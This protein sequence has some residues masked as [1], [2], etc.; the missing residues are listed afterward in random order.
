MISAFRALHR[1]GD[2][3]VLP[4][5]WDHASAA[6]LAEA[7]FPAI[8]TTS[9]GVAAA[10]GLH[11]GAAETAQ[12]TIDLAHRLTHLPVPITMDI[13]NGFSTDPAE[14]AAYLDRLGPVAGVN[15]EDQLADP[16]HF[17]QVLVAVTAHDVF[18]NARIDTYWLGD[19]GVDATLERAKAYVAAGAD[20]IFVPGVKEPQ[21]IARLAEALD[22]PLN[23]LFLPG[24]LTVPQLAE[25]G[26]A[27]ISTGSLLYRVAHGAAID[28]A[29]GVRDGGRS[30]AAPPYAAV[31]ALSRS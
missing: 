18:I 27:R 9:L 3:L 31:D 12:A 23:V 20:G 22:V 1:P 7:G 14:V 19:G 17:A 28:A 15:L 6:A 8:G 29:L 16:H 10:L 2:P 5:A 24:T 26:V 30:F 13:E 4:N 25:L 21:E 11:D